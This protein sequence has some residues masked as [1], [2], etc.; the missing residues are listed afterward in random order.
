MVQSSTQP[1]RPQPRTVALARLFAEHPRSWRDFTYLYPVISRRSRGLSIGINVN[2]NQKCSFDCVYCSVDTTPV[3]AAEATKVNLD[4]LESELAQMLELVRSGEIWN[5]A[6]L[7]DTPDKYRRL[8]DIAFS[9]DGEPTIYP[10]LDEAMARVA[11][12]KA[13]HKLRD[14]RIVLVTN[15]SGLERLPARRRWRFWIVKK[16]RSGPSSMPV[17][18]TITT[19][20]TVRMCLSKP[21]CV[22]CSTAGWCVQL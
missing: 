14:A 16:G 18:K 21:S 2:L 17:P 3:P 1:V 13:R 15:T 10:K 19:V 9:G 8:N 22:I 11:A 12:V 4:V 20:S 7:R 5:D 6:A